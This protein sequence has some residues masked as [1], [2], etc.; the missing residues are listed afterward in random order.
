MWY[1]Q[2]TNETESTGEGCKEKTFANKCS[3]KSERDLRKESFSA[4][5]GFVVFWAGFLAVSPFFA[6]G[7]VIFLFIITNL[8]QI[9]GKVKF[10]SRL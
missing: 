9:I 3:K 1:A 2:P 8:N 7:N 4:V 10:I 6:H 5:F